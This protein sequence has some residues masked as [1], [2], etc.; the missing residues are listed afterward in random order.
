LKKISLQKLSEERMSLRN[1]TKKS[2][3][4]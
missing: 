2:P 1:T 4:S 3:A